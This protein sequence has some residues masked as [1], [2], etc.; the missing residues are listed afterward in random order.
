[1]ALHAVQPIGR[2]AVAVMLNNTIERLRTMK[3]SAFADELERQT[4]DAGSYNQLG[5]EDRLALLVDSEWNRRQDG[6]IICLHVTN[7]NRLTAF[8]TVTG[9]RFKDCTSTSMNSDPFS[10]RII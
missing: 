10:K 3:M 1:M 6:K 2:Q 9:S 4:E 8:V 7:W 5:F